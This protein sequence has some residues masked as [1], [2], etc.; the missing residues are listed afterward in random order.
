MHEVSLATISILSS[1]LGVECGSLA[2]PENGAIEFS[3]GT[4][5]S[6]FATYSCFPPYQ[7]KGAAVRV[8]QASG[9]WSGELPT[10]EA[11][12]CPSLG[13]PANGAV[14]QSGTLPGSVATYGCLQGF[15]LQG[16]RSRTCLN[17]GFWSGGEPQC[18]RMLSTTVNT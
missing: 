4:T 6:S 16:V 10:C 15:T 11:L 9:V 14:T 13:D 8:C 5:F 17:N 12:Q 7:L 2:A 3:Q 1:L 18:Q